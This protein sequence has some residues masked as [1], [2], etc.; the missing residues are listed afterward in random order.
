MIYMTT[1]EW[2]EISKLIEENDFYKLAEEIASR[3]YDLDISKQ[4]LDDRVKNSITL[5]EFYDYTT[6]VERDFYEMV[7]G[8]YG[9]TKEILKRK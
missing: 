5:K 2:H 4:E 9:S 1:D 3:T 8:I 7:K 6:S